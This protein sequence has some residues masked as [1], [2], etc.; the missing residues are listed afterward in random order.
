MDSIKAKNKIPVFAE[1]K[2]LYTLN[3]FN[4]LCEKKRGL[5][6]SEI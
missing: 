6:F 5:S 3:V 2:F 4:N 1:I